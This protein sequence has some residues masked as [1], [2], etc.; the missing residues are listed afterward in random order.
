[1]TSAL[2][3]SV[4]NRDKQN[5]EVLYIRN[6]GIQLCQYYLYIPNQSVELRRRPKNN[7]S[8]QNAQR[9]HKL[10]KV[11]GGKVHKKW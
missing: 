4:L 5:N 3:E 6:G 11:Q 9:S 1:M 10:H 7:G 2:P 8:L